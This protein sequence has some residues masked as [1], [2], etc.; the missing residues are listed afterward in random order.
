MNGFAFD[1]NHTFTVIR[2]NDFENL[3]K[4]PDEYVAPVKEEYQETEHLQSWLM[5]SMARDQLVTLV[6]DEVTVLWN[7]KSQPPDIAYKKANWTDTRIQWSPFGTYLC[8]FH[9]QGIA[10]WGGKSWNRIVRF[11]HQ[12]VKFIDF[13]PCETYFVTWSASVVGK[14]EN[15]RVW[16]TASG[17]LLR[18]FPTPEIQK[19]DDFNWPLFKWSSDEKYVVKKS[20]DSLQI[21]EAPSMTLLDNKS[22][23]VESVQDFCWNPKENV[24]AYWT[25]EMLNTPARVTLTAIPSRSLVRTKNLVKVAGV[26]MQFQSEGDFFCVKVDR[27]TKNKKS[28]FSTFEVFFLR[29]KDIPVDT[30]EGFKDKTVSKFAWEPSGD[31]IAAVCQEEHKAQLSFLKVEKSNV[32]ELKSMD[33][34]SLTDLFWSPTGRFI[35]LAGMKNYQGDMEFF[36]VDELATIKTAEHFHATDVEWDPSGRYVLTSS[37]FLKNPGENGVIVWDFSGEIL[38]KKNLI[39]MKLALWRPRPPT[40]L[41]KEEMKQIRKNLADYSK[42]FEDIDAKM[43]GDVSKKIQE[44]RERI[45]NEWKEWRLA[46]EKQHEAESAERAAMRGTEENPVYSENEDENEE[47]EEW[48]EEVI[49]ETEEVVPDDE[50]DD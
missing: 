49:E 17:K 4:V 32:K 22:L 16:D 37:S 13:S 21:Y 41:T 1:K 48:V 24:L 5:D 20:K 10:L 19:A 23:K 40:L 43:S 15:L 39:K 27:F 12:N 46:A 33:R 18:G 11:V 6:G 44:E 42:K 50:D 36:D 8:T 7:N 30:Y 35:V 38:L 34:K 28:T 25:P 9:K 45:I 14:D 3:L 26:E 29:E 47:I 31:R 2:F